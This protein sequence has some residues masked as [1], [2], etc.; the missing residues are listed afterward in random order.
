MKEMA[1][2]NGIS[3]SEGYRKVVNNIGIKD[4]QK[5]RKLF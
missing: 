1:E 2:K 3:I 4:Q 5:K